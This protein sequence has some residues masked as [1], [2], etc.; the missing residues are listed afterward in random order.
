VAA[1]RGVQ[2]YE[3]RDVFRW[4]SVRAGVRRGAQVLRARQT[5]VCPD[6]AAADESVVRA[7]G[8]SDV[9]AKCRA[10]G[11]DFRSAEGRDSH[12]AGAACLAAAVYPGARVRRDARG[13]SR[14]PQAGLQKAVYLQG[15]QPPAGPT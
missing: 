9:R 4:A 5:A 2:A 3:G 7:A 11:H 15:P 13:R 12:S 8:R 1:F 6:P 14:A 10:E